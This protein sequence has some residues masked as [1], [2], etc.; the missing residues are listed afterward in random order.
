MRVK[1]RDVI[2]TDLLLVKQKADRFPLSGLFDPAV[3]PPQGRART[4]G[5]KAKLLT[6]SVVSDSVVTL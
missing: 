3:G 4:G 5:A 6:A 1:K 2:S